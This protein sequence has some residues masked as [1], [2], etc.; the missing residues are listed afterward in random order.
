MTA[1]PIPACRFDWCDTGTD[2]EHWTLASTSA[3]HRRNQRRLVGAG[4]AW[5]EH[6]D[7]HP[8]VVVHIYTS[9]D[10]VDIDAFL[11]LDEAVELRALL[12]RAI[13]IVAEIEG[14]GR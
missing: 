8:A 2:G 10:T 1:I 9:D 7:E 4:V 3:T 13:G 5:F 14:A 6:E 11:R 12:D